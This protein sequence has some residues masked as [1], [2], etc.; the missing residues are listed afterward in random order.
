MV[1]SLHLQIKYLA[2]NEKGQRDEVAAYT[3][4]EPE[5]MSRK[6]RLLKSLSLLRSD[7]GRLQVHGERCTVLQEVVASM[8]G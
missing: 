4:V 8:A 3:G 7:R 5:A 1:R 2:R 6:T